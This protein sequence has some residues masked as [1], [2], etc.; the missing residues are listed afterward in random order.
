MVANETQLSGWTMKLVS[1]LHIDTEHYMY[2]DIPRYMTLKFI[3][4][5]KTANFS[6][7]ETS[8]NKVALYFLTT[9]L[10]LLW[11]SAL[12]YWNIPEANF[13]IGSNG[14]RSSD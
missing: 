3:R 6:H 4:T 8:R 9:F 2:T 1:T 10:F 7:L 14:I 12:L 5:E 13:S 11:D